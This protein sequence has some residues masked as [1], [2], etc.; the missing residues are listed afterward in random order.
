MN[1]ASVLNCSAVCKISQKEQG[2]F[3][4]LGESLMKD[5]RAEV[6]VGVPL[7]FLLAIG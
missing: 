4:L 6:E 1:N 7:S 3:G 5:E 2:Q